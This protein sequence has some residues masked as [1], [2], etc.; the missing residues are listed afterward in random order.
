VLPAFIELD[1]GISVRRLVLA[2]RIGVVQVVEGL[3]LLFE[4]VV[5][6]IERLLGVLVDGVHVILVVEDRAQAPDGLLGGS[7]SSL[8]LLVAYQGSDRSNS[9]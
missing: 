9:K 1:K 4:H 3:G 7:G 2:V 5:G 6:V 8:R